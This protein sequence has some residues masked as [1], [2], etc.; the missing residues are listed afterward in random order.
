MSLQNADY[1]NYRRAVDS[2][3]LLWSALFRTD[4]AAFVFITQD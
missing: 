3:M 1:R 4:K 2:L